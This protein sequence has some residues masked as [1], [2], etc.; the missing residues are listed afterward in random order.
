MPLSSPA[1]YTQASA[2]AFLLLFVAHLLCLLTSLP[3]VHDQ[4][5][6]RARDAAAARMDWKISIYSRL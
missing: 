2:A 1:S 6:C 4:L 5:W 3:L